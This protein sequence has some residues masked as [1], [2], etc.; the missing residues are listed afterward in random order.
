MQQRRRRPD[1]APRW[2]SPRD[3]LHMREGDVPSMKVRQIPNYI[4]HLKYSLPAGAPERRPEV[5]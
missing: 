4:G 5:Q 1:A 3:I 2:L